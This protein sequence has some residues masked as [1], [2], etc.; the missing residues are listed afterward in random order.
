MMQSG[1]A[2]QARDCRREIFGLRAD[3]RF[4]SDACR[5]RAHRDTDHLKQNGRHSRTGGQIAVAAVA[6]DPNPTPAPDTPACNG[7]A[8]ILSASK[9]APKLDPRIVPD[10]RWPKMYRLRLPDGSLSDMANLTRIKDALWAW[11]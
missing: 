1:R 7:Y 5:N 3:A 4:C 6:G 8:P 10:A 2:C 11:S 9:S